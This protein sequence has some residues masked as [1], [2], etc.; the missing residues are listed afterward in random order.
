MS[1]ELCFRFVLTSHKDVA[2]SAAV[3]CTEHSCF[4]ANK[5]AVFLILKT[6]YPHVDEFT[7][8]L[9]PYLCRNALYTGIPL[10]LYIYIYIWKINI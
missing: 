4:A 2:A 10:G 6:E 9:W 1:C 5:D 8:Q 3:F 7:A